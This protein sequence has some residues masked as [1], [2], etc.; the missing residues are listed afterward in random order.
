MEN[1]I[2]VIEDGKVVINFDD[3]LWNGLFSKVESNNS[4]IKYIQSCIPNDTVIIIPKSDGNININKDSHGV[5]AL[6]TIIH[7]LTHEIVHDIGYREKKSL[8]SYAAGEIQAEGMSYMVLKYFKVP[9]DFEQSCI[10]YMRIWNSM[11]KSELLNS[12]KNITK[13]AG[14]IINKIESRMN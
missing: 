7:E 13:E 8:K 9:F 1:N 5:R 4:I 6:G 11:D 2:V 14:E 3:C 10:N 12:L